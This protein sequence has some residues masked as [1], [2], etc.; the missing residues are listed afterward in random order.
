VAYEDF[1]T[2]TEEDVPGKITVNDTQVSWSALDID[3]ESYVYDDKT[4][5]HFDGDFEHKL[6]YQFSLNV[7]GHLHALWML[8]NAIDDLKCIVDNLDANV[9]YLYDVGAQVLLYLETFNNGV[10]AGWDSWAATPGVTYYI[11]IA[12]DDDGG[13]SS[14]GQLTA[15]IRT[16]S[17]TGILQ[18][19][20]TVDCNEQVDYQYIYPIAA[21]NSGTNGDTC[22]GFTRNLD[23][24]EVAIVVP[25]G[26]L[27]GPLVGP[28]GGPI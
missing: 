11:T 8:A 26:A 19:T 3:D 10:S 21:F 17:H 9:L 23:L 1:D 14:V 22:T 20:L 6:E 7:N 27:Y 25:T 4:A 16:G 5:G 18:T 15:D 24:Q 2:Y 12:R 28:L 13:G